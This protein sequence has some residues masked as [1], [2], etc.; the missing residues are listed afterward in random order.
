MAASTPVLDAPV[1][2]PEPGDEAPGRPWWAR[3]ELWVGLLVVA[4]CCVFVIVQLDPKLLLRN[5]TPAGGDTGGHVWWPAYLRDHLLPWRLSGWSN[6]FYDGFPAGQFYFPVPALLI[7]ALNAVIPYNVAF[8]LVTAL[9]PVLLPL[10]AYVLGRGLRAR[11]PAPAGMAVGA[12]AFLFFTGD[13]G[14][15]PFDHNTVQFDQHIMGGNL[16]SNLAGEF[17]YTLALALAL[18]FLGALAW[19]L[20]TRRGLWLPAVL[21]ALTAMS[22]LVVAVFAVFGAVLVVLATRTRPR[23]S[24]RAVAGMGAA[25]LVALLATFVVT[26]HPSGVAWAVLA[27]VALAVVLVG[28]WPRETLA[29]ALAIGVVGALLT[30]VWSVPLAAT[31]RYTTDMRYGTITQYGDFLF[32][33]S[34]LWGVRGA[35][36][37]QW[38]ATVL[39]TLALVPLL[40]GLVARV[41]GWGDRARVDALL[42]SR[43]ATFVLVGL[44]ALSGLL[45]RVWSSLRVAQAWNLRVLPFWYLGVYL[46]MGVGVAELVRGAAWLAPRA[47]DWVT[48]STAPGEAEAAAAVPTPPARTGR[49]TPALVGTVTAAVLTVALTVGALVNVDRSKDFLPFW[50]R[51]NESGYQDS[52]GK[53]SGLAKAYPEYRRLLDRVSRLPTGRVIVEGGQGLDRYGTPL[54]LFLLPYWT[55]GR[56]PS[57]EGLYYESSAT[58]PYVFMTLAA[59]DGP[60]IASN[61]VR[62]VPYKTIASFSTGVRY[63]QLLGVRYF[64][65][66]STVSR[67]AAGADP[68]LR[69]VATSPTTKKGLAPDRWGVYEV[70]RSPVVTPLAEQPVVADPLSAGEQARCRRRVVDEGVAPGDVHL[71]DWQDCVAVPWFDDATRLDRPVVASG[72]SGW[73][74]AQPSAARALAV[75]PLPPVTVSRV[76]QTRTGVSFHVS[77]TGVPVLVKV[78][79][80]PNWQVSGATGVYRST[81]NFMVVVPTSHDVHLT[82]STTTAEWLGRLLTLVGLA[83][84]AALVVW[85]RRSRSRRP[86]G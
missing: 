22:H 27:V 77:R 29:R 71:H 60:G 46:L 80:F 16:A 12:T 3:L 43:R 85:G 23:V 25:V 57:A 73:Q 74:H 26:T 40:G 63:L 44:T 76:R 69:L 64:L 81:P 58:T 24:R 78:S 84:I 14:S 62:G 2:R 1:A 9:G 8:K 11:D 67:R 39:I 13:P 15:S 6:D 17:S 83:G 55:D 49:W 42:D 50:V 21:L 37:W 38:G 72:P 28:C 65:A 52:S 70:Q 59:L 35:W 86:V 31:L 18:L 56:F 34:Y 4:A 61:P 33:F 5:T 20:R 66:H 82:Y 47:R 36:P 79:Y 10:G 54:A 19:A 41:A 45:F 30:A 51:W 53:G 75:R 68:R 32:P 7:V 48:G